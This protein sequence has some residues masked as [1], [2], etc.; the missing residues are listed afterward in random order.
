MKKRKRAITAAVCLF[1]CLATFFL[2]WVNHNYGRY[3]ILG[4]P[5]LPP[6]RV[7]RQLMLPEAEELFRTEEGSIIYDAGEYLLSLEKDR[8]NYS[9]CRYENGAAVLSPMELSIGHM[10]NDIYLPFYAYTRS[11]EAKSAELEIY[12]S[13]TI[14]PY[15]SGE[16]QELH[17]VLPS[18]SCAEGLAAFSLR[19]ESADSHTVSLA[20]DFGYCLDRGSI[21]NAVYYKMNLRFYD[22]EGTLISESVFEM[23]E[24]ES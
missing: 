13:R 22:A 19:M 18:E 17:C 1:L 16:P 9:L 24:K 3:N 23:G 20:E 5:T 4:R 15:G 7:I 11:P 2:I 12:V 6:Q 10:K 8:Q 14:S 21:V